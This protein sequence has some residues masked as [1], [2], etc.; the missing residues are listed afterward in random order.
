M[1]VVNLMGGLGN[2][3]FQYALG[4]QLSLL[5]QTELLLDCTFLN[6]SHPGHIKRDYELGIFPIKARIA[7]EK[8]LKP[9]RR[10]E[11]NK[12]VRLTQ[13]FAPSLFSHSLIREKTHAFDPEILTAPDNSWLNGFWQTENYFIQIEELIRKDFE[14]S[15]S[16]SELNK[17]LAAKITSCESLG[18]HVRRG[19][20]T[21][22]ETQ[23]Y[24][25]I[26][27]MEY[28]QKAVEVMRKRTN[29]QEIFI[30]SDEP[31]W[32]QQHLTFAVPSTYISHNT[33]KNSYEDMRLMSLCKHNIIAN[34]S[35]SWWG[36]WLN[37]H[38]NRIVI[39]PKVWIADKQVN[40]VDV[41]P[42]NWMKL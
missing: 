14:F 10:L 7:T 18:I 20:Y 11:R 29:I 1:I 12:I 32:V 2:Q 30:F 35:F 37:N 22:P 36:A 15:P 16:L 42:V 39:A 41:L 17:T 40:T 13:H 19:D 4:R 26:C 9:Y 34:S 31:E 27:S 33:G 21:K 6:T 28:Y 3:M 5:N 38:K 25:G 24:H 23:A 8:E